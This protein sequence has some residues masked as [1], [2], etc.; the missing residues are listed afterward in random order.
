MSSPSN[1]CKDPFG[2]L[3]PIPP[4]NQKI[5][6]TSNQKIYNTKNNYQIKYV[7]SNQIQIIHHIYGVGH[8]IGNYVIF[9]NNVIMPVT[10][11]KV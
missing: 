11:T 5:Y 1:A 10:I 4:S 2:L 8:I 6:N 7:N 3:P 9:N